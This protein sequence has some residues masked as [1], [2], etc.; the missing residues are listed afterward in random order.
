MND[1]VDKNHFTKLYKYIITSLNLEKKKF[2]IEFV[3]IEKIKN[4]NKKYRG[5]DSKTD[6]ISL[7]YNNPTFLGEIYISPDVV[8]ENS[9]IYKC[10]FQK[11]MDRTFIHAILHLFGYD[12]KDSLNNN[13]EMFI[14]QEKILN[15]FK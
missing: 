5:I 8:L 6:V 12:H 7:E 14:I 10:T 15:G 11:E 4:L 9:K 1:N 13:E 2:S 3:S